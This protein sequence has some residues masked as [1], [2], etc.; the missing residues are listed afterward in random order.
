MFGDKFVINKFAGNFQ[1][2]RL[3]LY[4]L[5]FLSRG[6][7]SERVSQGKPANKADTRFSQSESLQ[8][9]KMRKKREKRENLIFNRKSFQTFFA[10]A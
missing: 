8:T 10:R 9:L 7:L 4:L 3:H 2:R 6:R 5:S 1:R